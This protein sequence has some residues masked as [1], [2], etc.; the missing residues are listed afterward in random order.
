MTL[1]VHAPM[2]YVT[3]ECPACGQASRIEVDPV[4][5]QAWM[6]GMHI[7]EAFPYLNASKRELIK[8]GFHAACWNA[9]FGEDE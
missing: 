8:S 3:P 5:I 7:Q 6:H 4:A 9:V 1:D 2:Q